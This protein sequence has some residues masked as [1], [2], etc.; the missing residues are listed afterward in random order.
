MFPSSQPELQ[1]PT[2]TGRDRL[3]R[4]PRSP[5][6]EDRVDEGGQGVG[7][8][9]Q[10]SP[11]PHN[12]LSAVHSHTATN[13]HVLPF[14]GPA[15][16]QQLIRISSRLICTHNPLGKGAWGRRA[17][18]CAPCITVTMS[19]RRGGPRTRQSLAAPVSICVLPALGTQ[20]PQETV[21]G[22]PVT[23]LLLSGSGITK[24]P[25]T[26]PCSALCDSERPADIPYPSREHQLNKPRSSLVLLTM[27][28]LGRGAGNLYTPIQN[29]CQ[30]MYTV[31]NTHTNKEQKDVCRPRACL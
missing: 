5:P 29:M 31:E 6:R 20:G 23:L 7:T 22:S 26:F 27:Q 8:E 9:A 15:P 25:E 2:F 24:S 18:L 4:T 11:S 1:R 19:G 16:S 12:H 3:T 28:P 14:P 13:R 10:G 21:G 30:A 17:G